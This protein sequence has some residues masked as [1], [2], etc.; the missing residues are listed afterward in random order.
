M[1]AANEDIGTSAVVCLGYPL[2]VCYYSFLS[3]WWWG[4]DSISY[5]LEMQKTE[6]FIS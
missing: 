6:Q 1:V 3:L 4:A 2:K 5:S